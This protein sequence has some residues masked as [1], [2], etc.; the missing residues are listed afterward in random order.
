MQET[1]YGPEMMVTHE[2]VG[3]SWAVV[4]LIVVGVAL[5]VGIVA[6]AWR[7]GKGK[8]FLALGIVTVVGFIALLLLL[9]GFRLTSM[10]GSYAMP[11][12]AF[13]FRALLLVLAG[14][15]L[16][17]VGILIVRFIAWLGE[18]DQAGAVVNSDER[19]RIMGMVEQGKMT[20]AEGAELLDAL[21][22]SS[23]L[24]AQQTFG[25]L[26]IA[27]LVASALIVLGFFLPWIHYSEKEAM[28]AA[29]L[30]PASA[31]GYLDIYQTG[32]T[33]GAVGYAVLICAIISAML[34]FITPKDHLYKL[35]LLQVLVICVGLA[36]VVA[37]IWSAKGSLQAG[38]IIC[39]IGY[40]FTLIASVVKL[41]ALGR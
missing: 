20:G 41:K 27:M 13:G 40:V 21:G 22:R 37:V 16:G 10:Q 36:L 28:V 15:V 35:A 26:D 7:A 1:T 12:W 8:G 3:M 11:I 6:M 30:L 2:S 32:Y 18:A 17:G 25:R 29:G 14:V 4:L 38:I 39:L 19:K 24:R 5:A 34:V 31:A 9:V 23:A 33:C